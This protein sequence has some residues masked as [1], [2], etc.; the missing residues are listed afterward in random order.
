MANTKHLRVVLSGRKAIRQWYK[1]NKGHTFD[2]VDSDLTA[3]DLTGYVLPRIPLGTSRMMKV[4]TASG[5]IQAAISLRQQKR[6][7]SIRTLYAQAPHL[8]G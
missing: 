3:A 8:T 1:Q 2:L 6:I 5:E 7:R 4:V